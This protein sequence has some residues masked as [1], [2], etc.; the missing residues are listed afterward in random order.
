VTKLLSINL[1]WLFWIRKKLLNDSGAWAAFWPVN[2]RLNSEKPE[3]VSASHENDVIRSWDNLVFYYSMLHTCYQLRACISF[4]ESLK[5]GEF[6]V[7]RTSICY[8]GAGLIFK[9]LWHIF[10]KCLY[11][12]IFMMFI[13]AET[14]GTAEIMSI[15]QAPKRPS[16]PKGK[17][18]VKGK[19]RTTY[20]S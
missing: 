1:M 2:P 13:S 8:S 19:C 14:Q 11:L 16:C 20:K 12:C 15:I 4:N 5:E 7:Y 6:I 18:L 3:H 9:T 17:T 10:L